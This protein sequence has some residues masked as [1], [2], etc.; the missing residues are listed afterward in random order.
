MPEFDEVDLVSV[1]TLIEQGLQEIDMRYPS[2]QL[3]LT[4]N[5]TAQEA[6]GSAI[7]QEAYGRA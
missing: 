6:F 4:P 1:E 7:P 2:F 3:V 5:V